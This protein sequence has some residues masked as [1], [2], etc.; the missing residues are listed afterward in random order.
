MN[1]PI[2]VDSSSGAITIYT[3]HSSYQMQVD[4]Y[5]YLLHLHYGPRTDSCMDKLLT[6]ADVGFSGNPYDAGTDRTYSLDSLPQEYPSQGTGDY[7]SPMLIVRD[8]HGTYGCDLRCQGH[9]ITHGKYRLEGLPAVCSESDSDDAE[10]LTVTLENDRTG[11]TV[12]LLYGVLPHKDII[13]RS[14]VVTNCGTEPVTVERLGSASLDFV[15]GS[16]DLMTFYGR[17][18]MEHIPE[19]RALAHGETVIGSRR[20]YSSHQF[21][22]MMILL[23]HD[24]TETDG[25]RWAMQFVYS[26]G[27][28]ASAGLD[29]CGQTRIQMGLADETFSCPLKP[30]ESLTAPEVIMSF[31]STGLQTLS[32]NL[33]RCIRQ[34]ICRG[35][36]RDRVRP[37]LL[38]SWET[39]YFDFTGETL[40]SL[41]KEAHDL[42]IEMLVMDDGWFGKRDDDYRSLGDWY[43]NETKLG[44]SLS[45]L[46]RKIN[47]EGLQ[48]GIWMEP[49]M[50]SEDS[51][52]YRTHPDWAL[53]IPGEK[54]V[55]ARYQLVL[56]LSRRE[57]A[58]AVFESICRVLDQGP[59][60]YLKWDCNRSIAEAYSHGAAAQGRV[61]YDYMLGLYSI[62]DRLNQRYP[63]LLIESCSGGGGRFDAGMLYYTPQIWCSDNTD[64]IDRLLIQYGTS[65]GYPSSTVGA[66]VSACPNHITGRTTPLNTRGIVA[67]SG[68]FG[69]ELNLT[70]L[71]EEEKNEIRR[72]ITDFHR[73]AGLIQ[74]GLYYRLTDPAHS[75]VCA[76]E[77]ISEDRSEALICAVRIPDRGDLPSERI[78]PR[79]LKPDA[80]YTETNTGMSCEAGEMTENGLL[81]PDS[82]KEADSI[83]FH[84]KS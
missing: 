11:V 80:V 63:D 16:F 77:Y 19:R 1:M 57:I 42:G 2:T 56:D 25:N 32:H 27:F 67:M 14:A 31:S 50:V 83:L 33:H 30:G 62:L 81:L 47:E 46:I 59:V 13:T 18:A 48:F 34:H 53:T 72:Q 71:S 40:V 70:T 7:R 64:A 68:T 35:S 29:Q 28:R 73:Y 55:R 39:C 10:S 9:E 3:D 38:N 54:P 58:D 79:G 41:A 69:Y 8:H 51:D 82:M 21:N 12:A 75:P 66:H 5:G 60:R 78:Y 44:C 52:L 17:H 61:L 74:N 43:A 24:A 84:F 37:L 22:P 15:S 26:G 65:F 36:F 76:W 45:E 6:Y 23:D 49:E 20:G 4:R